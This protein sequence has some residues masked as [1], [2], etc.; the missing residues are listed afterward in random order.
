MK[1]LYALLS[2]V[3]LSF[4]F[5]ACN[6]KGCSDPTA[7]NY[8][9]KVKKAR[10]NKCQY[11]GEGYCG[12]NIKFC[13]EINGSKRYSNNVAFYTGSAGQSVKRLIWT[14]GQP[15]TSSS[16]EDVVIEIFGDSEGSSYSLSN[17]E[18]N[19]TFKASYVSGLNAPVDAVSGKLEVKKDN[20]TDGLI[21]T[22]NFTTSN[23]IDIKSGNIYKLK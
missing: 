14:N 5:T 22:F 10:D 3:V 9:K 1:N 13:F 23:G 12:E 8:V 15:T 20:V 17:T 21:A 18:G 16:Y 6:K 4:A 2:I 7:D 19:K 11:N